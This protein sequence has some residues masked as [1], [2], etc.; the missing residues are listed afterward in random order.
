MRAVAE[1]EYR[2]LVEREEKLKND[3]QGLTTQRGQEAVLRERYGLAKEGEQM[4]F[5]VEP[6]P[7]VSVATTSVWIGWAANSTVAKPE[8]WSIDNAER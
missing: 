7:T 5:I 6:T 4:V 2:D 8:A 1:T 3:I